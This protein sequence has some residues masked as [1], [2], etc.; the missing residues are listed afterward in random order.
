MIQSISVR[1]SVIEEVSS[2]VN[3]LPDEMLLHIFTFLPPEDL[4]RA[5]GACRRWRSITDDVSLWRKWSRFVEGAYTPLNRSELMEICIRN[6]DTE[7]YVHWG[8]KRF[9]YVSKGKKR[10][11]WL[12]RSQSLNVVDLHPFSITSAS[13]LPKK[14]DFIGRGA[15]VSQALDPQRLIVKDC[16]FGTD[17]EVFHPDPE[18]FVSPSYIAV[19]RRVEEMTIFNAFWDRQRQC[20]LHVRGGALGFAEAADDRIVL[21][22]GETLEVADAKTGN[23]IRS[24]QLTATPEL[25]WMATPTKAVVVA[26]NDHLILWDLDTG[27]ESVLPYSREHVHFEEVSDGQYALFPVGTRVWSLTREVRAVSVSNPSLK[28]APAYVVDAQ[29]NPPSLRPFPPKEADHPAFVFGRLKR[30][31][32][33]NPDESVV[34]VSKPSQFSSPNR[35]W[36]FVWNQAANACEQSFFLENLLQRAECLPAEKDYSI[37]SSQVR[38]L[39]LRM[40]DDLEREGRSDQEELF[41]CLSK[42]WRRLVPKTLFDG[43]SPKRRALALRKA[44]ARLEE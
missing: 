7:R 36:V 43:R 38:Q 12:P 37:I 27:E 15:V 8:K 44:A 18:F 19:S 2:A 32:S 39:F 33:L 23:I 6:R 13:R 10:I 21:C 42:G 11:G 22:R 24:L 34:V 25:G 40:A 41:N 26:T 5:G 16:V 14:A 3:A 20:H 17:Y 29:S 9:S 31:V 1:G 35:H 28:L 30:I 4:V